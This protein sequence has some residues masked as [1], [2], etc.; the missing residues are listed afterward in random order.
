MIEQYEIEYAAY[1]NTLSS[2]LIDFQ[3]IEESLKMN[4]ASCYE[5]VLSSLDGLIPFKFDYNDLKKDALGVL[6][7]KFEKYSDDTDLIKELRDLVQYRNGVAHKG[8]L[9]TTDEQRNS[10]RLKQL[11]SELT[12][13]KKRTEV[14]LRRLI[15]KAKEVEEK[16]HKSE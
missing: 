12:T 7:K 1:H 10:E 5:I 8:W 2:V 11:T 9:L 13:T 14:V 15:D 6:I 3:F 4:I 16:A